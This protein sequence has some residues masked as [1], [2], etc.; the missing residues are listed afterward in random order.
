MIREVSSNNQVMSGV[1]AIF[2][3]NH[4]DTGGL[5]TL[6]VRQSS[7]VRENG[8]RALLIVD[9]IDKNMRAQLES[10]HLDYAETWDSAEIAALFANAASHCADRVF[11]LSY[12]L[13][14]F[15]KLEKILAS[16]GLKGRYKHLLYSVYSG[17]TRIGSATGGFA[18]NFIRK[19][20]GDVVK[21]CLANRQMLFMDADCRDAARDMHDLDPRLFD[22]TILS[23]AMNV[24]NNFTERKLCL[25]DG[26]TILTVSRAAFPFKGYLVGLVDVFAGL[27]SA[28]KDL[29]LKIVSFGSDLDTLKAKIDS[30]DGG[31][32]SR[33]ELIEGASEESIREMVGKAWLYIGMGTTVLNAAN[34]GVPSIVVYHHTMDC[35]AC[36][37]FSDDPLTIGLQWQGGVGIDTAKL[38]ERCM[39]L[40]ERDYADLC[41]ATWRALAENYSSENVMSC[42]MRHFEEAEDFRLSWRG[43]AF[44]STLD[45]IRGSR[46]R[47]LG[48][49]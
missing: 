2:A 43:W 6:M 9:K 49:D 36:G 12:E 35:R 10:A 41:A 23:L 26:K 4:F 37:L 20:Y 44:A 25:L 7:W 8:G 45:N 5:Q 11:L 1:F 38:V 30:C 46:R 19:F 18:G 15:L 28:G 17:T 32:R 14:D 22:D 33:I 21:Q 16:A 40:N 3:F 24:N 34:E 42:L 48:L 39:N 29:R 31:A 13:L 27:I 47:I